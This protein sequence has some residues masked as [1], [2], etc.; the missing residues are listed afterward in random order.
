M[1]TEPKI[2]VSI[3]VDTNRAHAVVYNVEADEILTHVLAHSSGAGLSETEMLTL[4]LRSLDKHLSRP[5]ETK[6]LTREEGGRIL[7]A[8]AAG[9][10]KA[11]I[12][13]L[14][15]FSDDDINNDSQAL[16]D[17]LILQ[18]YLKATHVML[19]SLAPAPQ[20]ALTYK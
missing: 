12:T 2:L 19:S 8:E 10:I 11:A 1:L 5:R 15:A 18:T 3:S 13:H 6:D 7:A 9:M 20:L 16:T 4:M 17:I 14:D